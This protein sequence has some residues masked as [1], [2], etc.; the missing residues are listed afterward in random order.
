MRLSIRDLIKEY[1]KNIVFSRA[2]YT[3]EEGVI[4]ALLGAPG[5]GK[6]TLID[7]I[8]GEIDYKGSIELEKDGELILPGLDTVGVSFQKPMVPEFL[9]GY[10]YIRFL[11]DTHPNRS[12]LNYTVE[13]YLSLVGLPRLMWGTMIKDY[14]ND[15]KNRMQLAG[16]FIADSAIVLLDEPVLDTPKE[17]WG[18]LCDLLNAFKKGHIII[19]ATENRDVAD[20]FAD[21]TVLLENGHFA[22]S[23]SAQNHRNADTVTMD[24]IIANNRED[25]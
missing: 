15:Y 8:S 16:I 24:E 22:Q 18:R 2:G 14:S 4:Y 11:L 20:A 9:T 19:I 23:K 17:D 25:E 5:T 7:C 1:E 6:T 21:E 13:E 3:F 10:E 12:N